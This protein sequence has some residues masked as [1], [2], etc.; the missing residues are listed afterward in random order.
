MGWFNVKV[1]LEQYSTFDVELEADDAMEA[2]QI[3]QDGV[4]MDGFTKEIRHTLEIID[5]N[6][7]AVEVCADCLIELDYC[8]C[9]EDE[10]ESK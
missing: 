1:V 10:D 9:E 4:W 7:D 2:E 6:Y 8:E 3:V 5:E